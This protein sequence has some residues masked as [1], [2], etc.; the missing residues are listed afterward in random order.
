ML[1]TTVRFFIFDDT[2]EEDLQEV[3]EDTFLQHEGNISYE[4]HTMFLNGVNQVCLTKGVLP[5]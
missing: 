5:L 2:G 3:D 1:T 4:R